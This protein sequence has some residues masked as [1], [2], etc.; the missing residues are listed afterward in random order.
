[1]NH[2][3]NM[4]IALLIIVLVLTLVFSI[5]I[6]ETKAGTAAVRIHKFMAIDKIGPQNYHLETLRID[7]P[8]N[9]F[10]S[11]YVT[12]M[13]CDFSFSDP[14]NVSIAA[15]LT[16]VVPL[17]KEGKQIINKTPTKNLANFSKSIGSKVM[18]IA[19][20]YDH[21]KNVLIYN[22]Y[23]TKLFDGSLKHSMSVVPLGAPLSP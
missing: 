18:K 15:R 17:D 11:I 12:H 19:R 2:K 13:I 1:M 9:P 16:G 14:S 8:D 23:T 20:S 4:R 10:V 7:D 22:A 21:E 6:G 5:G 3:R